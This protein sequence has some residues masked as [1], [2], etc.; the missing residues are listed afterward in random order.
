MNELVKLRSGFLSL[1]FLGLSIILALFNICKLPVP[2]KE[3]ELK[4]NVV[5]VGAKVPTLYFSKILI[6]TFDRPS[7]HPRTILNE[8]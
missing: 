1:A 6:T 5:V 2:K 4:L 8:N 7:C 3:E